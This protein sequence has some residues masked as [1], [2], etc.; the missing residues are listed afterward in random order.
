MCISVK[1]PND[2]AETIAVAPQ[3]QPRPEND[4]HPDIDHHPD[5]DYGDFDGVIISDVNPGFFSYTPIIPYSWNLDF[6][7][8]FQGKFNYSEFFFLQFLL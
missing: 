1:D 7:S 3:H 8:R 6:F 4:A 2:D 5:S